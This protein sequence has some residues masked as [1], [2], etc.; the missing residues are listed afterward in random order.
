MHFEIAMSI[1]QLMKLYLDYM[2]IAIAI[3]PSQ[4][5]MFIS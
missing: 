4:F 2:H 3:S 1:Q 5:I